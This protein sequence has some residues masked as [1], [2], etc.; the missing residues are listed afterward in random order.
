MG[1]I[2]PGDKVDLVV[3]EYVA[4][5][6]ADPEEVCNRPR[7]PGVEAHGLKITDYVD[8][9]ESLGR[10]SD[11]R[12]T[13]TTILVAFMLSIL[14]TFVVIVLQGLGV[15]HLDRDLVLTLAVSTVGQIAAL[16]WLIVRNIFR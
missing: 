6:T 5:C 3:K 4:G 10:L 7:D 8:S 9:A 12:H 14:F 13:K 11:R 2:D 1:G 15:L 16:V